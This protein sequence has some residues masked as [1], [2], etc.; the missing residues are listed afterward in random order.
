MGTYVSELEQWKK[1]CWSDEFHFLL[2]D[3]DGCEVVR[4]LPGEVMAP[5]CAVG[6]PPA[7]GESVMLWEM[8]CWKTLGRANHLNVNLTQ[9]TC[10][11][12]NSPL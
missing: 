8:F 11:N 12:I 3:M 7:G 2:H 6:R 10:L 1:V 9:S 4:L 5:G